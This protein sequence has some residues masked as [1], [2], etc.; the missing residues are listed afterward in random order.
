M[1]SWHFEMQ[2]FHDPVVKNINIDGFRNAAMI[3]YQKSLRS[4]IELD[5]IG[6]DIDNFNSKEVSFILQEPSYSAVIEKLK[7]LNVNIN[8]LVLVHKEEVEEE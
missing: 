3:A 5:K 7:K 1:L 2:I 8:K 4:I 6:C